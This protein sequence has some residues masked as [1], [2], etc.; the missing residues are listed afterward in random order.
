VSQGTIGFELRASSCALRAAR[1]ELRAG[2]CLPQARRAKLA[3]RSS[4]REARR[5][6][7]VARDGFTLLELILVL[8]IVGLGASLAA[9]RLSSMRGTVGA[10]M[11]AQTF[12]DQARRCQHLAAT[13]GQQV[14]LRLDL[15]GR[16]LDVTLLD[17]AKE[18]APTDGE[19]Q[20]LSLSQS[21]DD[22]TISFARGDAV[23]ARTQSSSVDLLFSPDQ[24]CEPA[25]TVTFTG[26]NHVA[27]VRLSA[28]ARLPAL[29][30][31]APV[32]P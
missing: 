22:L 29:I 8:M 14:R 24:R 12:V 16:T 11:A 6:K 2:E 10:D 19:D 7:L 1:F 28:G 21:A 26:S 17:G 23:M 18:Q 31:D 32:K 30:A 3:A 9:A 13:S 4:P 25:G 27:S 15:T 20:H 5:A